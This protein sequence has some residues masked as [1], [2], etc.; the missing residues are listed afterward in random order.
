MLRSESETGW[1]WNLIVPH[2]CNVKLR[3]LGNYSYPENAN[4]ITLLKNKH[5]TLFVKAKKITTTPLYR[6]THCHHQQIPNP[7]FSLELVKGRAFA[8]LTQNFL[9]LNSGYFPPPVTLRNAVPS[10]HANSCKT[11]SAVGNGYG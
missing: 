2:S 1:P 9:Y 3:S 5:L 4:I 8:T 10:R 6:Q 11:G 7:N